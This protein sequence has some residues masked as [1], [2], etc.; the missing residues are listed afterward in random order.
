MV[1]S[2]KS[3]GCS[4][5]MPP[6]HFFVFIA[7]SIL[8][9]VAML[10]WVLRR[11]TV[12]PTWAVVAGMSFIVVVVGMCFGKLGANHGLPWPVYY[13]VPALTTVLLPPLVLRM[14]RSESLQYIVLAAASAPAIHIVFSFFF[15]WSEYMAGVPYLH[16]E[17][18]WTLWAS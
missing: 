17:P 9:F 7:V 16:V 11:R 6:L 8:L 12:A 15:G 14:G 18:V 10:F 3:V 13:G 2:P 1:Y 5:Q 4:V